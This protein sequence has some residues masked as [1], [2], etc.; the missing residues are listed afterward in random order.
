MDS[1]AE[2]HLFRLVTVFAQR[3][4][5]RLFHSRVEHGRSA[6]LALSLV[7]H[8]DLAVAC[9]SAAV[10]DLSIGRNAEPFLGR[11]VRFHLVHGT[12][13][14]KGAGTTGCKIG[15]MECKF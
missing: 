7:A 13:F 12:V 6:Q 3:L 10:L 4:M 14:E 1:L 15:K 5:H 9:P 8:A 11:F 2:S